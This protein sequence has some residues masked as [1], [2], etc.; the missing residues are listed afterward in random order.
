MNIGAG[1]VLLIFVIFLFLFAL[2]IKYKKNIAFYIVMSIS[3]IFLILS[4][5][6]ITGV[7]DPYSN[8]IR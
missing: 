8:H 1:F 4:I 5:L 3:G 7:Y 6:L 2:I